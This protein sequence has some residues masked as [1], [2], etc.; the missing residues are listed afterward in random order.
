[1]QYT[2]S[3]N[4]VC[5]NGNYSTGKSYGSGWN[6]NP[7]LNVENKGL[8]E[9]CNPNNE[10]WYVKDKQCHFKTISVVIPMYNY[11]RY[12]PQTVESLINQTY[13]VKEIIM[14]NDGSPDNS[15][16]VANELVKKYS[17]HKLIIVDKPNGGLASA[18][19]AGIKVTTSEYIMCLDSD[20]ILVPGA[21]AEHMGLIEDD[22][23]VAQ[24]GLMEFGERHISYSPTTPTSLERILRANTI[25]CNAV[26]SKRMWEVVGGYDESET[27]RYGREDHEFWVRLLAAGCYVR[28]S[29]FIALRY[30]VH[31][32]NMT[33]MT[34]HPNWGKVEEYFRTKHRELYEK[35]D[36]LDKNI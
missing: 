12:L 29:D 35:Y 9:F 33:K 31:Q 19:N 14:V 36:L 1:M 18:R 22:M 10:T 28:T 20:D 6:Q 4:C 21:I 30:R 16:E 8:C 11:G 13:P 5:C 23:T 2:S 17:D 27:L 34:L 15:L 7:S 24:C 3:R 26:F 32:N 25:F